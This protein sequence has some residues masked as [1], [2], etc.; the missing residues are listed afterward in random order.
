MSD[1]NKTNGED[2]KPLT[3]NEEIKEFNKEVLGKLDSPLVVHIKGDASYEE[4]TSAFEMNET[5]TDEERPTLM[6]HRFRKEKKSKKGVFV[7]LFIVFALAG[8]LAGLYFTG[9]I[10][11]NGKEEPT[12]EVVETTTETTTSIEENYKGKIVI[13]DIY[14]FV[15]GEEV[16]GIQGLQNALKYVDPSPTA[17]EIIDEHA[18]SDIL[19]GEVLLILEKM[20]FFDST[21]QIKHIEK[22]GLIAEAETTTLPPETTTKKKSKSKKKS[23][24]KSKSKK[25]G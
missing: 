8:V 11:F 6:R 16:D 10:T 5:H 21:T 3:D 20:G 15:D 12:T 17:Y 24:K 4:D 18:N 25:Q 19:N 7:F 23:K 22:T 14:I 1:D 9:N 13:K 2:I